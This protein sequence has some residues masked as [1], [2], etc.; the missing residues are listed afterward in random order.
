MAVIEIADF[1]QDLNIIGVVSLFGGEI[2]LSALRYTV[3]VRDTWTAI[4]F[5]MIVSAGLQTISLKMFKRM[6]G[7]LSVAISP[8]IRDDPKEIVGLT[9]SGQY[10]YYGVQSGTEMLV[11]SI[12]GEA[13]LRQSSSRNI[14]EVACT[15]HE[16]PN[17][18]C[19]LKVISLGPL[20]SIHGERIRAD[21]APFGVVYLM[22]LVTILGIIMTILIGDYFALVIVVCNV[23][24]NMLVMYSVRC[25]GIKY[26]KG[27]A[28]SGSPPGNIFVQSG[29]DTYLVLGEE[30]PIQYL[31]QKALQVPPSSKERFWGHL[32]RAVAYASYTIVIA[33]IIAI[34]FA[35]LPGQLIFGILMLLGLLQNILLAT[36]DG[37]RLLARLA[38]DASKAIYTEEFVF[39]TRSSMIAFCTLVAKA[40]NDNILR[41]SLPKTPVFTTWFQTVM[42]CVKRGIIPSEIEKDVT[43]LDSLNIDLRDAYHEYQRFV[44]RHP[45]SLSEA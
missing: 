11:S 45:E 36:F 28:S 25:T 35:T 12:L 34:P 44:S 5:S 29:D 32:Q 6:H 24:C 13:M 42:E 43:L 8:G 2:A 17:R 19:A 14:K 4:Y 20:E 26:P 22:P 16:S 37:D 15:R 23:L 21:P 40:P 27:K 10:K 18:N 38:T 3:L 41:C 39:Q 1:S 9:A 31:F 30:D 33:N 7:R